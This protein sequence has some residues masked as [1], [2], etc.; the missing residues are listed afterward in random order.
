VRGEAFSGDDSAPSVIDVTSKADVELGWPHNRHDKEKRD[1]LLVFQDK[2]DHL[3]VA[4]A[5]LEALVPFYDLLEVKSLGLFSH[6]D[7]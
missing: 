5:P 2:T 4:D 7:T 6:G 3:T 1:A